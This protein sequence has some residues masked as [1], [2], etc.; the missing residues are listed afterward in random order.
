V[1]SKTRIDWLDALRGSPAMDLH[2]SDY[3]QLP[4]A[5]IGVLEPPDPA[6]ADAWLFQ[7]IGAD[8]HG[9]RCWLRR[10]PLARHGSPVFE[11]PLGQV[12]ESLPHMPVAGWAA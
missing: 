6:G 4:P 9:N 12:Q 11:L 8:Q 10:W 2:Q 5:A 3:I 7:V 1:A